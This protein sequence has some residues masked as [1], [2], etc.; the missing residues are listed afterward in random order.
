MHALGT[1]SP[2]RTSSLAFL[3]RKSGA[4]LDWKRAETDPSLHWASGRM[5]AK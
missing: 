1:T 4:L 5:S 3:S 2:S